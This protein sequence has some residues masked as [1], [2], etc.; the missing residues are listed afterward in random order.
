[1]TPLPQLSTARLL[2]RPLTPADVPALFAACSDPRLT[3]FTLFDTHRTPADTE[4][5]VFGYALV[6]YVRGVID[7]F[8]IAWKD[9]PHEVIGCCGAYPV[10]ER[11]GVFECGYW[12]R[13]PDWGKGV[14]TEAV[15]EL[16]RHLFTDPACERVRA[17]VVVGNAASA[18][19][20]RKLG[21][22]EQ[23]ARVDIHRRGRV[24]PTDVFT[25]DRDGWK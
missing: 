6:N 25:R 13:V 1:M 3:A 24:E 4:A 23:P 14:A 20:L 19:V 18:A 21:F 11:P 8:G 12:V 15:G 17:R 2:L 10:A 5:F 16:V 22:I 7:P 9:S